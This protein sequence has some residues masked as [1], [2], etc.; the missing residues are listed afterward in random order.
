MRAAAEAC[1]PAQT[2]DTLDAESAST[3]AAAMNRRTKRF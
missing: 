3:I 2:R 1:H